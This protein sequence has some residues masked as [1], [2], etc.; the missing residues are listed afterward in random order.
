MT[1]IN[2]EDAAR[3]A[4]LKAKLENM[5][6]D[7][8]RERLKR[9]NKECEITALH[10]MKVGTIPQD[11]VIDFVLPPSPN[12]KARHEESTQ[13][14]AA[15]YSSSCWTVESVLGW[16][17]A[18]MLDRHKLNSRPY[19]VSPDGTEGAYSLQHREEALG[20]TMECL[21]EICQN[22]L[23]GEAS[24]MSYPMPVFAAMSGI[25]KTRML[26]AVV[27]EFMKD[28][29]P[30]FPKN[31]MALA[32]G[33]GN[34]HSP[35][36]ESIEVKMGSVAAFS[37]RLLYAVF[38]EL[39]SDICFANF[40]DE[41]SKTVGHPDPNE[42]KLDTALNAI[43]TKK[44]IQDNGKLA[45]LVGIDEFQLIP[46][47]NDSVD[48]L[49]PLL[50]TFVST[51]MNG[52]VSPVV[53]LPMFAGMNWEKITLASSNA[54]SAA[55]AKASAKTQRIPMELLT[56][57]SIRTAVLDRGDGAERLLESELFCRHLFFLGGIPRPCTEYAEDC[58]KWHARNPSPNPNRT[59]EEYEKVFKSK[60]N[61]FFGAYSKNPDIK[62]PNREKPKRDFTLQ[63][64]IRL[65]AYAVKG[66]TVEEDDSPFENHISF[67]RLRDGS[68]CILDYD[69]KLGLPY[70]FFHKLSTRSHDGAYLA[71]SDP[72]KAFLDVLNYLWKNVD[73][74]LFTSSRS[75]WQ[76]WETFGACFSALRINA[77]LIL[78][79]KDKEPEVHL[80][81]IFDGAMT[82]V[83]NVKVKLRPT[84]VVQTEVQFGTNTPRK[85]P[86]TN[87]REGD[88]LQEGLVVVNGDNGAGV[89]IFYALELVGD[90]PNKYVL[91][92][93]QR[94]RVHGTL[95]VH[96][97]IEKARVDK[98]Q[99]LKNHGVEHV[100]ASVFSMF[101]SS[102]VTESDLPNCTVAV[103]FREH[104]DYHGALSLH[105]AASFI[106]RVN[107]DGV[108]ALRGLFRSGATAG[109]NRIAELRDRMH[110]STTFEELEKLME[111]GNWKFWNDADE[112]CDFCKV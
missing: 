24:R 45:L 30:D 13:S 50:D 92:T 60:F 8:P 67:R 109:A 44:G 72:E 12:K 65:A 54:S 80:E 57:A 104:V 7:I 4:E 102:D 56:P 86:L 31:K 19:I 38:L 20:K 112:L 70:C 33:Y 66:G 9:W 91:M 14:P 108:T 25:G 98:E 59:E 100:V 15:G 78:T 71:L 75:P 103:T 53:F 35:D 2:D 106:V 6:A 5:K 17:E 83:P 97:V 62:K 99:E 105:P 52:K 94:K 88:W 93:D 76:Q 111:G 28:E 110:K 81:E 41:L 32:L 84:W 69:G 82:K 39:N 11:E 40:F 29:G 64:L 26:T 49:V 42:L 46:N 79:P 21:K 96:D 74:H 87:D 1:D 48:A 85:I 90:E 77:L 89:D 61:M 18:R 55:E 43:A 16:L 27:D 36:A 101:T 22:S 10:L 3:T 23:K 58:R 51:M 47:N 107:K 63:E 37:W 34:G 68:V 95:P 73:M